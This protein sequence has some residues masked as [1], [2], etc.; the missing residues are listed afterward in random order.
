MSE[1]VKYVVKAICM[2]RDDYIHCDYPLCDCKQER[3]Q[4]AAAIDT[5]K[6]FLMAMI[7]DLHNSNRQIFITITGET[8][9][10]PS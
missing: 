7:D 3:K 2:N 8:R 5:V 4:A 6:P 1:I 10:E 9:N